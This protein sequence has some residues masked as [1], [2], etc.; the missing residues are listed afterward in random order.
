M[1]HQQEVHQFYNTHLREIDVLQYI[2]MFVVSYNVT[3]VGLY[4]AINELVV[5]RVCCDKVE[6]ERWIDKFNIFALHNSINNSL[7]KFRIE[8]PFQNFLVFK[9]YFIRDTQRVLSMQYRQPDITVNTMTTNALHKAVCVENN[10]HRLLLGFFLSLLFAQPCMKIHLVYFIKTLLIKFARL[11][12]LLSHFIKPFSIVI[13]YKLFNVI[14]LFVA[15]NMGK[16]AEKIELCGVEH[17]GLNIIHSQYIIA[18]SAAKINKIFEI[19]R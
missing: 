17:R 19:T 10:T 18:N 6:T 7:G 15:F 3:C 14:Q 16:N 11:P 13:G 9:K 2:V 8:E 1:N 12:H 5:V 4:G